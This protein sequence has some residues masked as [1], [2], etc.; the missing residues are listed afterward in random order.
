MAAR[1]RQRVLASLRALLTKRRSE[2]PWEDKWTGVQSQLGRYLA[3][4]GRKM[5]LQAADVQDRIQ[6]VF[7]A[8]L[9]RWEE[10]R[11]LRGAERLLALSERIMHDRMVDEIRRR[12]RHR[13]LPLETLPSEPRAREP[14]ERDG[15]AAEERWAR[16]EAA[17]NELRQRR[18][19][20]YELLC[21]YYLQGQS[22][23]EL[24]AREGCS[25]HAMECRISQ[26]RRELRRLAAESPADGDLP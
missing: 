2:G 20:Y 3:A 12:D 11:Q 18:K 9:P 21:A 22:C 16:L 17:L 15:L 26:A 8:I 13:P 7:L 14:G 5:G 19:D 1:L 25:V 6:E 23:E 24:A 10:F 4:V